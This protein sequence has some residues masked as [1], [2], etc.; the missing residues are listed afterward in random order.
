MKKEFSEELHRENDARAREAVIKYVN[1]KYPTSP[2][3]NNNDTYGQDLVFVGG[4][5]F[6][7]VEV[8]KVWKGEHF[9]WSTLQ[10]PRRKEKFI[11]EVVPTFFFILNNELTHAIKV[12]GDDLIHC[13]IKTIDT[14][15]TK[16]EEFFNV[17]RKYMEFLTLEE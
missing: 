1:A 5:G 16:N 17:P 7:E 15:Y 6:I 13:P 2:V 11:T 8:K 4:R 10:I 12:R 14:I 9:P 3:V